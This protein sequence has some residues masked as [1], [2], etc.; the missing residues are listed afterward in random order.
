[1]KSA[2]WMPVLGILFLVATYR[3]WFRDLIVPKNLGRW[4]LATLYMVFVGALWFT[5][6]AIDMGKIPS[7]AGLVDFCRLNRSMGIYRVAN[8]YFW[9]AQFHRKPSDPTILQ[10]KIKPFYVIMFHKQE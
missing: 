9:C 4:L 1:M 10:F 8:G 3:W 5:G 2:T 7:V 6:I